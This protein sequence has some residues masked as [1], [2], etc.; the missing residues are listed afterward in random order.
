MMSAFVIYSD[1]LSAKNSLSREFVYFA[2]CFVGLQL[3]LFSY[4]FYTT[5]INYG[6]TTAERSIVVFI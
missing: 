3:K 6:V 1:V 5:V 2:K 4:S